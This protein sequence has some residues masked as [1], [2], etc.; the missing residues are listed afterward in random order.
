M[1]WALSTPHNVWD[2][3]GR[4]DMPDGVG[5]MHNDIFMCFCLAVDT[6]PPFRMVSRQVEF[7]VVGIVKKIREYI[8][9]IIHIH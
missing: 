9:A 3:S 2:S 4:L 7:I 5:S 8:A 6:Q 1:Y